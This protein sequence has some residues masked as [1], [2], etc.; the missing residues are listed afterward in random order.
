MKVCFN[1]LS[2][3]SE[4]LSIIAHSRAFKLTISHSSNMSYIILS[5]SHWLSSSSSTGCS[6]NRYSEALNQVIFDV[7]VDLSVVPR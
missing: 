2:K 4:I 3:M 7:A 5:I 6:A 1:L